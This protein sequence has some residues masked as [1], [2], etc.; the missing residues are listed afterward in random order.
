MKV[1]FLQFST[2]AECMNG[3]MKW[4]ARFNYWIWLDMFRVGALGSVDRNHSPNPNNKPNTAPNP[5]LTSTLTP[6]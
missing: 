6:S 3:R 1:T 2:P 4:K 5:N